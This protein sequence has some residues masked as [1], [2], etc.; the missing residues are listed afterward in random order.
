MAVKEQPVIG[1]ALTDLLQWWNEHRE[2]KPMSFRYV[3]LSESTSCTSA[4]D[5]A[6]DSGANLL[7]IIAP[8]TEAVAYRAITNVLT[9]TEPDALI[10]QVPG[11][12]DAVWMEQVAA[13]RDLA[14]DIFAVRGDQREL[15]HAAGASHLSEIVAALLAAADRRTPVL[16]EGATVWTAALLADRVNIR[17][18]AWWYGAGTCSDPAV[19]AA[20]A[21]V[22]I[23]SGLDLE[24]PSES[25]IGVH[26]HLA[27]LNQAIEFEQEQM[28]E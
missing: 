28:V 21:R 8:H 3:D 27:A 16:L 1:A 14:A 23:N 4:I 25:R 22:G 2:G 24:L 6:A 7:A 19:R 9:G 12:P 15:V 26:V 13:C 20:A 11:M 18:K 10:A 5:A 17:A